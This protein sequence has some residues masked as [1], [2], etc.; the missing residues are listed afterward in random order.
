MNT[1]SERAKI[2]V[3][4]FSLLLMLGL[5]AFSAASTFQAV[6][7]FQRQYGAVRTGDVSTIHPWMTLPVVSHIYH[8]PEDYLY[9]S[10]NI[11]NPPRRLHHT[12]IYEIA[13]Q[14]KQSVDQVIHTIQHAIL[15]YRKDHHSLST[16]TPAPRPPPTRTPAPILHIDSKHPDSK[17]LVFTVGRT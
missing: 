17:H 14:Q 16:P 6:H 12:T 15:T 4:L 8:V 2:G 9:Q 7:S 13:T 3:L 11:N 1:T 10:L 5:L